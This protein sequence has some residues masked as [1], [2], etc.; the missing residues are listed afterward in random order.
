MTI[1]TFLSRFERPI[2]TGDQ[3]LVRCP[4]HDDQK[5]SLAVRQGAKGLLLT[6]H[7]GC[8]TEAVVAAM[9]LP[10]SALFE[11]PQASSHRG[12]RGVIVREYSY[13]DEAGEL[14]HQTVR[15][16]PKRFSQRRPDGKG[17][18][19][20]NLTGVRLVLYR[21]PELK[22]KG[23][24]AI[25]AG[26]KDADALTAIGIPATTNALGEGKWR[27]TYTQQLVAAG[28]ERVRIFPDNDDP[29]RAHADQVASSCVAGGIRDVK[30]IT[31]PDVP[32]KGDVSDYLAAG[33]T[34]E[35]ILQLVK[36][37]LAFDVTA[38]PVS[39]SEKGAGL[40]FQPL[41][42]LLAEP[43]EVV[44]WLVDERIACGS[45][46]MLAGKPKAGKSTLTRDLA[47]QVARGGRWLGWEC[48]P[49]TVWYLAFEDKKSEVRKHFRAMGAS[50][51]DPVRFIFKQ[52]PDEMISALHALAADEKPVLIIVDTLQR[53]IKARDLN[54]YAEVTTKLTAVLN[55][56]RETGTAVVLVHHAGKG[57]RAG[58]DAVLGSTALNGSMDNVFLFARRDEYRVLSSEQRIGNEFPATLVLFDD[59]TGRCRL[60][61]AKRDADLEQVKL[62]MLAVLQESPE[63]LKEPELAK[64]VEGGRTDLKRLALRG[65]VAD[66][67]VS[68]T[69]TGK[70]GN[71]F[72]YSCPLVPAYIREQGNTNHEIAKIADKQGSDS[73]SRES[74][75]FAP[76]GRASEQASAGPDG[77]SVA[78][79]A[80]RERFD[81]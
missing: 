21:L 19:L 25:C 34:K 63:P 65:L 80:A 57:D 69:G 29:G 37:T 60:G 38:A 24:V 23:G 39:A 43:D 35:D 79:V 22:G 41:G 5:A 20:W 13:H 2:R 6:C 46:N 27:D 1:D 16:E 76:T 26:E 17:G 32:P 73:C 3:Y 54:D 55:L 14:R 49:G 62:A 72:L 44:E 10:M 51:D 70:R 75:L 67:R 9:G 4:A 74:D 58:M 64:Q 52:P 61:L 7:A 12:S 18:W 31:L 40:H 33:H 68:R 30:I 8:S 81:L 28:V 47:L 11:T 59:T 42:D 56:C 66:G 71:P 78:V 15:Y 50:P 36:A 77:A 45:L 48:S 53:L